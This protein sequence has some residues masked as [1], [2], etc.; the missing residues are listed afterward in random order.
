MSSFLA[1]SAKD[2]AASLTQMGYSPQLQ[3]QFN[4]YN[5]D[6]SF[7]LQAVAIQVLYSKLLDNSYFLAEILSTYLDLFN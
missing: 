2:I 7:P 3:S 5:L 4:G 6:I 1:D